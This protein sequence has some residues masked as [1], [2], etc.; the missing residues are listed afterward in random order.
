MYIGMGKREKY[1]QYRTV[2]KIKSEN[3]SSIL[4]IGVIGQAM[5]T[6]TKFKMMHSSFEMFF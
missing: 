2:F 5:D 3:T 4:N 1:I 6:L